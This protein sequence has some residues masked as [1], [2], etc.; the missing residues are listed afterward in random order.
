LTE[1]IPPALIDAVAMRRWR[2]QGYF[3]HTWTVDAPSEI[4]ALSA[5]GVD[6]IITNT[7]AVARACVTATASAA[8]T[9]PPA[10]APIS[11]SP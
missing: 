3:V 1:A 8:T 10:A 7:P 5:L 6:A 9:A 2:T 11:L 4:A